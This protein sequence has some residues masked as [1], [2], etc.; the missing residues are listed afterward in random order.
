MQTII[1]LE[2]RCKALMQK[3]IDDQQKSATIFISLQKDLYTKNLCLTRYK[4]KIRFCPFVENNRKTV[5]KPVDF[6]NRI[7]EFISN[8]VPTFSSILHTIDHI[9]RHSQVHIS[10]AV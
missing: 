2:K 5:I 3:R 7:C 9:D 6:Q 4:P 8:A 1:F 10:E